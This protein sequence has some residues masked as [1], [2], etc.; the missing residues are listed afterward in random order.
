MPA[1]EAARHGPFDEVLALGVIEH[2]TFHQAENTFR[3]VY[4]NLDSGGVFLFDVPDLAVWCLYYI[5]PNTSMFAPEHVLATIYGW[6]RW[7]GDEHKSGWSKQSLR[8]TLEKAGFLDIA[9]ATEAPPS[10]RQIAERNR[11]DR[12]HDAHIYV[13]ARK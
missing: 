2:L 8:D 6:Q 7:P 11:F 9:L 4:Q 13:E 10:F 1:W 3:A 5:Y 12:P